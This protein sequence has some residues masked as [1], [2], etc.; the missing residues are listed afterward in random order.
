MQTEVCNFADNTTI[1]SCSPN[2]EEATLKLSNDTHLIL[3]W[4]RINSMVANP[5]KFQIMF[6]GS[7]I[8]N[9]KITFM[10]EN[11]RVKSSSEVKLIGITIDDKL[12]FT[13]HIENLCST[14]SNCLRALARIRK[15]LS[16]EQAK[17]LSEVYII[18]TFTYCPLI[19]MFCS[20]TANSLINKIHKRSLRVIYEMEY[21][22]FEDLLTKDSSW[23]I[24]ENNIHTLLIEI[25]K[26]LNHIS[27]PIMQE[28]FDLKVTPYSF[29]N[30]NL[31]TLPKT[32][33]SRYGTQALCFKE[34]ITWNT[35]PNLYK[36]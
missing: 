8:D 21:A 19:W 28:F 13:S 22:N 4:F 10:I 17:R 7:N 18:S 36:I 30:S 31:L 11:K 15:F 6:L 3:N 25:Y 33:T 20:K 23:T 34:S 32:N 12:S 14:A 16:F 1:H 5:G 27:P 29:R 24:H 35:V 26:S 9:S 2:F